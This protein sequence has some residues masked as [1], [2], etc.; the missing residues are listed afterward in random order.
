MALIWRP[1]LAPAKMGTRKVAFGRSDI[2]ASLALETVGEME[3]VLQV[4]GYADN[5]LAAVVGE[6][7]RAYHVDDHHAC[8]RGHRDDSGVVQVWEHRLWPIDLSD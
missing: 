6:I 7:E 1:S 5:H 3:R 8:F 4:V 2:A